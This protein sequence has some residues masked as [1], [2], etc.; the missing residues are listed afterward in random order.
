MEGN[1]LHHATIFESIADAIPEAPALFQGDREVSWRRFDDRAAR[2]AAA[3]T[4][5]GLGTQA[6]VA[7]DLYNS[8]EWPESSYGCLK[9]RFVPV[10]INYRYLD[11]ELAHLLET[12][13]SEALIYHASLG[14][15]VFRVAQRMPQLKALIQVD[16]VGGAELPDGVVDYEAIM[17]DQAP[18]ERIERS[19]DDIVMWFSGGTTGLPKGIIIP[20]GRSVES[21]ITPEARLRTLGRFTDPPESIPADV[22]DCARLLWEQGGRPISAAAAPLM[23]STAAAYAGPMIFYCGGAV[24]TLEGRSFD[25]HELL[26]AVDRRR[27]T[28]IAIVGDA[29]AVPMA[30]AFEQAA[31]EGRPYDASS[32]HTIYSAGVTWSADVK[33]RLLTHMPEVLLVDNCGSS[34]GAWYGMSVL[35]KGDAATTASFTPSEGVLVLD[36]DGRPLAPGS[37][38]PG[39]L[40]SPTPM[41]GYYNDPE[42]TAQ[43]FRTIDG[44]W[45]TTPGDLGILN[46]DGSLTLVGR[47][48]SVINTGGEKVYPEE[49]DEVVKTMPD[50]DDCLVF[51]VADDT[52]GQVVH[53]VVQLNA[54]A[55]LAPEAVTEWVRERLA[56]YKAPRVIHFVAR[57]PRLPNG[58]PDYPGARA[59]A[60]T[61]GDGSEEDAGRGEAS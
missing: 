61:A 3:L 50:V 18:M 40:A 38:R 48:S 14:E 37:G 10:S 42:K 56:R 36:D 22:V 29:F 7:I 54:G 39:L 34:E 9:G 47:G 30:R 55:V 23:H 25:P 13:E 59:V 58:K 32:V 4:A 21:Q 2:L 33:R 8:N 24:V 1:D 5:A 49:V 53:A 57:V 46:A 16:D 6:R 20:I 52:Y 11:D 51:G 44:E 15:R 12:S 45:Y 27:V 26:A 41:A 28:T 19:G 17:R 35:R 31:A 43:N 60:A